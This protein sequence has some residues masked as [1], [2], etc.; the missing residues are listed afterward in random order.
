[1]SSILIASDSW[2]LNLK[3]AKNSRDSLAKHL[4]TRLIYWIV[5]KINVELSLEGS[6]NI[7]NLKDG[8]KIG[9]LDIF[10][11][12]S[13]EN[14]R[15]EQLMINSANEELINAFYR[16]SS[17]ENDKV[18]IN[19][20]FNNMKIFDLLKTECEMIV[21]SPD[22]LVYRVN[23]YFG[24]TI[25]TSS[26]MT[27]VNS[28]CFFPINHFFGKVRYDARGLISKCRD[29]LSE[30]VINCLLNSQDIFVSNLFFRIQYSSPISSDKTLEHDFKEIWEMNRKSAEDYQALNFFHGNININIIQARI[31]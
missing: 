13:F 23:E 31:Q 6:K 10:G 25:T 21:N 18:Y 9:V 27:N 15:F 1:M 2:P 20:C 5:Q 28:S 3:E 29:N 24:H 16:Y 26:K 22:S 19:S 8:F 11:N 4:Y 7:K 17:N 30:N 12:E 14:N